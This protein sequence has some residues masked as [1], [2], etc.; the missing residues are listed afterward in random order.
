METICLTLNF[1][2]YPLKNYVKAAEES[3]SRKLCRK[4]LEKL[5]GFLDFKTAHHK[6]LRGAESTRM[7]L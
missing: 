5:A 4:V 3:G 6:P 7:I 1:S 2:R